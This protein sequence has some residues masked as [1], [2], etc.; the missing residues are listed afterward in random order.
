M[1]SIWVE[2]A[3]VEV[4]TGSLHAGESVLH[5]ACCTALT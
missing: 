2:Q 4:L 3:V 1:D 5:S